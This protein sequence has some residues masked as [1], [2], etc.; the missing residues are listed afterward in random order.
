MSRKSLSLDEGGR[1]GEWLRMAALI[2]AESERERRI[3]LEVHKKP[4][5]GEEK[6]QNLIE[7]INDAIFSLDGQGRFTYLSPVIEQLISYRSE[8][9][10]GQPIARFVHREDLSKFLY[11]LKGSLATRLKAFDFRVL[12][13][14]GDV[15]YLRAS[16]RPLL[17]RDELVG[18]AGI[19][20][21]ITK[22]KWTEKKIILSSYKDRLTGLYTRD[23]FEEDLK[24][25][26]TPRQLPLSII[27][28]DVNSLKLVN[29]VFGHTAGDQLLAKVAFV[30]QQCC[31]KEDVIARLGGDEF[32]ILLPKT[33]YQET[34]GIINR[35]KTACCNG[36]F[37]PMKL[38]IA[39]GAVTKEDASRDLHVLMKEAEDRMY[40]DK[41][42]ESKGVRTSIISSMREILFEKKDETEEHTQRVKQWATQVGLRL[43]LPSHLLDELALLATLH[44]IGKVTIPEKISQKP[45]KLSLEEWNIVRRHP[46]IGYRF[47]ASCPELASVA[48]AIL[49]HHEWWDGTGYP[50]G[51]KGEKIPLLPRILSIVDAYDV[52][53]HGR[54]SRK[55]MSRE[56]ALE[57][58]KRGAGT[59]FDPKLS[60][61]FLKAVS[62]SA[63]VQKALDKQTLDPTPWSSLT[64]SPAKG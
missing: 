4:M 7:N 53:T 30:L 47:A 13:K 57:E 34:I 22:W 50:R 41:L 5:Q 38:S 27:L 16:T 19:L 14:R 1:A 12:D 40:R 25:L 32:G 26:D 49:C 20:S 18:L 35:I 51:L 24:R 39:L 33:P 54:P 45:N 46:E 42:M 37:Y 31:R 21:D 11:C 15:R 6:F 17:V 64:P 8:E 56:T 23:Y 10:I 2:R 3:L 48:E 29:D 60:E 43:G 58:I 52:M 9:L 36:D 62:E 28:G 59:Q 61:V 55:P 44:D 63:G